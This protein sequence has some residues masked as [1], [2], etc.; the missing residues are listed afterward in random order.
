MSLRPPRAATRPP[1]PHRPAGPDERAADPS[2]LYRS[3]AFAEELLELVAPLPQWRDGMPMGRPWGVRHAGAGSGAEGSMR[4]A[5]AGAGPVEGPFA[6][7]GGLRW[8]GT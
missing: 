3:E 8:Q 7:L 2:W 5:D 6:R 4:H 1:A